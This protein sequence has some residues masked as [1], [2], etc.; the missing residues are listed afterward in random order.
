MLMSSTLKS[1]WLNDFRSC[2]IAWILGWDSLAGYLCGMGK[3]FGNIS[4]DEQP[5]CTKSSKSAQIVR[6]ALAEF[7]TAE[8]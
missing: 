1:N 5:E 3:A 7:L 4:P 2:P 6:R 8:N